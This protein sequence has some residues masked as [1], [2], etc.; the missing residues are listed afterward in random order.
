[1]S[2]FIS[3]PILL[4][5]L[6]LRSPASRTASPP[7][8]SSLGSTHAKVGADELLHHG[9]DRVGEVVERVAA[10]EVVHAREHLRQLRVRALE[11]EVAR[12]AGAVAG[13]EAH[14]EAPPPRTDHEAHGALPHVPARPQPR[15]KERWW[16][17]REG[18]VRR[19]RGTARGAARDIRLTERSVLAGTYSGRVVRTPIIASGVSGRGVVVSVRS[20]ARASCASRS[21]RTTSR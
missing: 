6:L 12:D 9:L 11:G 5:L 13:R 21:A 18:R 15:R 14:R 16:E 10:R 19:A 17:E 20:R 1:M 3:F 2:I 7:I 8:C 4:L